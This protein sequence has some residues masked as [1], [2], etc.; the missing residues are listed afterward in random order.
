[1]SYVDLDNKDYYIIEPDMFNITKVGEWLANKVDI[2]SLFYFKTSDNL[3]LNSSANGFY[4]QSNSTKGSV[5]YLY[6]DVNTTFVEDYSNY[7]CKN[8]LPYVTHLQMASLVLAVVY[9]A[10]TVIPLI[11]SMHPT[12]FTT[13][14]TKEG[15]CFLITAPPPNAM[16]SKR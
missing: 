9:T 4:G 16:G 2:G 15:S 11:S 5:F 12:S 8:I 6:S 3:I 10:T 14:L 1:M 13:L 7:Y